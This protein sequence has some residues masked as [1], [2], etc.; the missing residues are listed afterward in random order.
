MSTLNL[1]VLLPE[2]CCLTVNGKDCELEPSFIVSI[3]IQSEEYMVGSVGKDHTQKMEERIPILQMS[4]SAPRGNIRL[5]PIKMVTTDC[6]TGGD[7]DHIEMELQRN[8]ASNWR[9]VV[10]G[11][12]SS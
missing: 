3:N 5:Q 4:D 8:V 9:V 12:L 1:I 7:E 6:I 11:V 2:R 10:S